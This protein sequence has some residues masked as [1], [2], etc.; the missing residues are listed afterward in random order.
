MARSPRPRRARSRA[1][2]RALRILSIALFATIS[3]AIVLLVLLVIVYPAQRAAGTG[4]A[5]ELAIAPGDR[6]EAVVTRLA[7][8]GAIEDPLPFAIYARLIGADERLRAGAITL[9]DDMTPR[10]IVQRIA[11]G[12]GAAS[13]EVL[14]PEGLHRFEVAARLER[15]G[16]CDAD[17]FLA[18]STDRALLDELSIPGPSAEGY[19]FPDTYRLRSD[20]DPREVVRRMVAN[21]QR[22]TAA[23]F[24]DNEA[25]LS[26]LRADLGWGPHEALILASIVEEEAVAREEQPI[27][28]GVFLNR[29]RDPEFRPHR[30][31][32]DPTVSYGCLEMPE[33]APSCASFRGRISRAMTHD[34]GNPYNTYRREMLPP[35]PIS[36]PGLPALRAVLAPAEHDYYFFV[37]RGGGRHVFSRTVEE[38]NRAVAAQRE[39]AIG[40]RPA[41]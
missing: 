29:L 39:R 9:R 18:A 34:P 10:E 40:E 4:E 22:R 5:I 27:I 31:D 32:A 11:I 2:P 3:A 26:R 28:A 30:L 37:A 7:E 19:L 16:V 6:F 25:G 20:M 15:W 33:A 23:I 1:E 35:G 41:P 36:S 24:R 38:H 8:A 14:V 21:F 13:V 12:F 17:A